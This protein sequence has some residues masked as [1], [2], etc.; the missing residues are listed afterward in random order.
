MLFPQRIGENTYVLT[1]IGFDFI[2]DV[3]EIVVK[4]NRSGRRRYSLTAGL[5]GHSLIPRNPF[6]G[7][8]YGYKIFVI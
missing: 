3:N 7:E 1:P 6:G 5:S 4:M 2:N 8:Q